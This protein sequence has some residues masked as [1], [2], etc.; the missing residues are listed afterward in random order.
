MQ[1]G[2]KCQFHEPGARQQ[3][4]VQYG[5]VTQPGM[6]GRGER[7]GQHTAIGF[8]Q[9]QH[10]AHQG[11]SETGKARAAHITRTAHRI[12]P[13]PFMLERIGREIDL[14]RSGRGE[15]RLPLHGH[16][17]GEHSAD[18]AEETDGTAVVAAQ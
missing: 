18:G 9:G 16:T 12:Q 15:H 13:E 11:V 6:G 10:R 5:V 1:P 7:A 2:L 14:S 4:L 8:G 17:L 3:H